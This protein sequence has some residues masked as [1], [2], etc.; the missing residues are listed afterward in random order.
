MKSISA[1][2][3]LHFGGIGV[4]EKGGVMVMVEMSAL[5]HPARLS[6]M[7]GEN[8]LYELAFRSG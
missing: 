7:T 3:G 5:D 4:G 1:G 6:S 8:V 2:A